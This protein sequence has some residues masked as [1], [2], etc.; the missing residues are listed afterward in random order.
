[1]KWFFRG[2]NGTFAAAI[3]DGRARRLILTND[4][5]GMK[6]L[7]YALRPGR[8]SFAAEVK[9]LLT[10]PALS[11][12]PDPRGVAQFFT[13]G[14]LLGEDTRLRWVRVVPAA[15]WLTYDAD[16]GRLTPD[17]YWRLEPGPAGGRPAAAEAL[18]RVD[19]AFT[20]AVDRRVGATSRL[21]LS[22]SGGLDSR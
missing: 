18:D 20:R 12:R 7:Y 15:G 16:D 5:F 10:D 13:F 2:L 22:L 11:R 6:P 17:R 8:L 4:R 1:G 19:E 21:G 3:W 9:A 14:Q